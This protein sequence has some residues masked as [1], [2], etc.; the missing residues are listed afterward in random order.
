MS[1]LQMVLFKVDKHMQKERNETGSIPYT[2]HKN[3]FEMNHVSKPMFLNLFSLLP[4]P[5]RR[6]LRLICPLITPPQ[7]PKRKRIDY[8]N[9]DSHRSEPW[10]KDSKH[11]LGS[12][13][14]R[15]G[16]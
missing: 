11:Q 4:P 5:L 10:N 12:G 3:K 15:E 13:K 16:R 1:S 7:W 6:L 9:L 14:V 2:V 8:F